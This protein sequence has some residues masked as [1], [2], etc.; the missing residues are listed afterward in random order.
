ME[1]AGLDQEGIARRWLVHP[2]LSD[3]PRDCFTYA[4][5]R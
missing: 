2:N 1:K 5:V 4:A 3:E